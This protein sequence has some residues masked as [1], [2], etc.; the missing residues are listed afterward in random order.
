MLDD[1]KSVRLLITTV[2]TVAWI[3]GFSFS[4]QSAV[5]LAAMFALISCHDNKIIFKIGY[6]TRG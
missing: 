1:A 3:S 2:A 4:F 5:F 6:I